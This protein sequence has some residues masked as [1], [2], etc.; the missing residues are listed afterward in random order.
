MKKILCIL[1]VMLSAC[2]YKPVVSSQ[3]HEK[4]EVQ[5]AEVQGA[6]VQGDKIINSTKI[7]TKS[8]DNIKIEALKFLGLGLISIY[9]I[10]RMQSMIA[11]ARDLTGVRRVNNSFFQPALAWSPAVAF[12]Q[13]QLEAM[14]VPEQP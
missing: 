14:N 6:E 5:G 3:I 10:Y 11:A 2:G 8:S 1:L 9:S 7:T 4:A 13:Q 12:Q